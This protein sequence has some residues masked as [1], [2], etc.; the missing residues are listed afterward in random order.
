MCVSILKLYNV[1][2]LKVAHLKTKVTMTY[3]NTVLNWGRLY[4]VS[5]NGL[6]NIVSYREAFPCPH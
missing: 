6:F 2:K 5:G 1:V 4:F 3:K